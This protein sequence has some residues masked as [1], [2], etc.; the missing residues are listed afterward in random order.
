LFSTAA[1]ARPTRKPSRPGKV[2]FGVRNL[3]KPPVLFGVKA[4]RDLT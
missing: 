3:G 2:V 4:L 1:N